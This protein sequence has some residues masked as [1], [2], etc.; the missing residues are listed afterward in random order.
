MMY[1]P[2][3]SFTATNSENIEFRNH[4]VS[5]DDSTVSLLIHFDS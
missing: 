2:K 3:F 1:G 5:F 4:L